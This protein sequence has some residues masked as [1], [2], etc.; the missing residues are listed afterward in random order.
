[1]EEVFQYFHH[2]FEFFHETVTVLVI[3]FKVI[4]G[5]PSFKYELFAFC[6]NFKLPMIIS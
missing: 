3:Y 6:A 5:L 1:M 2:G 4:L